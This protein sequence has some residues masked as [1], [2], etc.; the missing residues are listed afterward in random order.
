[1]KLS[2]V[3]PAFNE[4]D[5]IAA[6]LA[7]LLA[8]IG[9]RVEHCELIVVDDHSSDDTFDR[10]A[11]TVA[12]KATVRCLR[13]SRRSGS[14]VAIRMGLEAATGDVVLCISADGQDD[15]GSLPA[16]LEKWRNGA[17]IVWA[18]RRERSGEPFHQKL[19]AQAF[20]RLLRFFNR[21]EDPSI[22]LSRADFYLL[23]RKVVDALV[24]CGERVTSLFGL[25]AWIGFRQDS[26]VYDRHQRRSGQS[27][28]S[29]R[30]RMG[31]ALDWIVAFSWLPLRI[32]SLLGL[33]IAGAGGLYAGFIVAFAL[34]G[35][36]IQ[37]W[38]SVMVTVLMLSGIQLLILGTIGEYV[39]RGLDESRKRPIAFIEREMEK[40]EH[41]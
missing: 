17:Q 29:F 30:R 12:P 27:K 5:N 34:L 7:E 8:Q 4:G 20:Y 35:H 15:A 32:S 23:D 39:G 31:L 9:E 38:A 41:S 14:H 24:A 13:L 25:V 1:V 19:F 6:T 2:V 3:I 22:D 36:P 16:M 11:A 21:P 18:L 33:V 10:V 26:V 37:G 28:W 40:N